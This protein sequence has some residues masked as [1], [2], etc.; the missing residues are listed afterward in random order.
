MSIRVQDA[1]IDRCK[2]H[3]W[4]VK[5]APIDRCKVNLLMVKVSS[6]VSVSCIVIVYKSVETRSLSLS[7]GHIAVQVASTSSATGY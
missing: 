4:I 6:I 2:A 3:L 7:K 1:P 5:V